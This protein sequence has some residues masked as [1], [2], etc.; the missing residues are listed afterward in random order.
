MGKGKRKTSRASPIKT[1]W[2]EGP[3]PSADEESPKISKGKRVLSSIA[4]SFKRKQADRS[5][6][7][8][9]PYEPASHSPPSPSVVSLAP[10]MSGS[11]GPPLSTT[12]SIVS[13]DSFHSSTSRNYEAERLRLLLRASHEDLQAQRTFYENREQAM[14]ERFNAE[15]QLYDDK[16]AELHAMSRGEGSSKSRRK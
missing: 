8:T 16:F 4:K 10:T 14:I 11:M 15:R 7:S 3:E 13:F 2:E 5:P 12:P 1:N 6:E 9:N